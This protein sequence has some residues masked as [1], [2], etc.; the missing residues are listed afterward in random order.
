MIIPV[1]YSQVNLRFT[2]LN[3]P[4]GGEVVFGIA[5]QTAQDP[6]SV[7]IDVAGAYVT[8]GMPGLF[9]SDA[10][11]TSIL[12]KNGPNSTGPFSEGSVN[13]PGTDGAD[14]NPPQ[15]CMLVKKS[16]V[17]GGRT[18]VGRSYWPNIPA[19]KIGDDGLLDSTYLST[20]TSR[21]ADFLALLDQ[22]DVPMVLLHADVASGSPLFV[23]SY[24]PQARCATQ[25]RRNRR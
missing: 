15:L 3:L 10:T 18:G 6:A 24:T 13:I 21:L 2:G 14:P 22:S 11:L 25:R 17:Q 4:T 1:G 20:A 12:C 19:N 23:N 9:S 8:A 16:T 7:I 5:N